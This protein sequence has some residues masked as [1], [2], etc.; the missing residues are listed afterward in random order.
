M[1]DLW[2]VAA[3]VCSTQGCIAV[4]I[5][6]SPAVMPGFVALDPLQTFPV[7]T[8][9]YQNTSASSVPS[10]LPR[11]EPLC[12]TLLLFAQLLAGVAADSSI[13]EK[14]AGPHSTEE[15]DEQVRRATASKLQ[16]LTELSCCTPLTDPTTSHDQAG[17]AQPLPNPS[18]HV[19][20]LCSAV[21][22]SRLATLTFNVKADLLG[23]LADPEMRMAVQYFWLAMPTA[24]A[25]ILDSVTE[26]DVASTCLGSSNQEEQAMR[27]SLCE[28]VTATLRQARK[29]PS[30][31][32]QRVACLQTL[33]R[34]ITVMHPELL[35]S[36][37]KRLGT[38][39]I[40]S[41]WGFNLHTLCDVAQ[42]TVVS[43]TMLCYAHTVPCRAKLAD[44]HVAVA[45]AYLLCRGIAYAALQ[46][47]LLLH[48]WGF[49]QS[50][51]K[52]AG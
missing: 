39:P 46:V 21:L 19:I 32:Q 40:A 14:T 30:A 6:N 38:A 47:L 27:K 52:L 31:H 25:S 13:S 10:I 23:T 29:R 1:Q 44:R 3:E 50:S 48:A 20:L 28:L 9:L 42:T 49:M 24:A 41:C 17:A 7:D 4:S 12:R 16:Q 22:I 33:L 15:E 35:R 18:K 45:F 8:L 43:C 26:P 34:L 51:C 36:E 5:C 2:V 11:V 37:T